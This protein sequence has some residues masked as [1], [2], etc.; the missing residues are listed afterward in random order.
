MRR[1]LCEIPKPIHNPDMKHGEDLFSRIIIGYRGHFTK[2]LKSSFCL[3]YNIHTAHFEP[4]AHED[5]NYQ[6]NDLICLWCPL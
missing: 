3:R 4:Y 1:C 6:L 2:G 5:Y